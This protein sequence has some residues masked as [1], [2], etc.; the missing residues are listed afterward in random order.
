MLHRHSS[1]STIAESWEISAHPDGMSV[2]ESGPLRGKSLQE[3]FSEHKEILLGR[4][5]H[6]DSFPLL[7]K[8]LDAKYNL[9]VQVHPDDLSAKIYG[10]EAK[11]EAWIVLD[12]TERAYVYVGL[13]A[14]LPKGELFQKLSSKEILSC[15]HALPARRGDVISI[16]GGRLHSLG[17]GNMVLE[18]QQPS[19][20]TYRVYDYDRKRALHLKEAKRVICC[21][22]TENPRISPVEI[23]KTRAYTRTQLLKTPLFV[24]EKWQIHRTMLWEKLENKIEILFVTEGKIS[25]LHRGRAT[26]LPAQCCPL[27]IDTRGGALLRVFLP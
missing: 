13:K 8:I 4:D 23:E 3:L 20:T 25:P 21:D 1:L 11:S 27:K 16:P 17:A 5:S 9:S 2:V 14:S 10:G 7:I 15:M 26:L 18:V 12:A 24:I 19:N 6:F 22:D